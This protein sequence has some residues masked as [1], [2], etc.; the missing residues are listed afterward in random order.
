MGFSH[1]V[2]FHFVFIPIVGLAATCS[3]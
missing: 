2:N 1:V 3:K